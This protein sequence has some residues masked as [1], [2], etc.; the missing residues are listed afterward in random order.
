MGFSSQTCSDMIM[1]YR[2]NQIEGSPD[3]KYIGKLRNG[4]GRKIG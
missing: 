4:N 2:S 1:T 3:A